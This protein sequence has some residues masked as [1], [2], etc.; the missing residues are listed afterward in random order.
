M[1]TDSKTVVAVATLP[2]DAGHGYL[3]PE[4][5][6]VWATLA[7]ALITLGLA[8]FTFR[9]YR[10]TVRI[11]RTS[12]AAGRDQADKMERSIAQAL[13]AATA[14]EDMVSAAK[15]NAVQMQG[16]LQKQMRA[17]LV[18]EVGSGIFQDEK[19]SRFGVL[20]I[21]VNSGFTP[22]HAVTYWAKAEIFPFPL[23]ENLGLAKPTA[24]PTHSMVLGPKQSFQINAFLDYPVS[25]AEVLP[26]KQGLVRRL[27]IWGEV[28]YK[29]V[30]DE[31][32]TTEFCQSVYW[33]PNGK[34]GEMIYGNYDMS[35][36][37][38]T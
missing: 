6:L 13:R 17:Y 30:F 35:R 19:Q 7:L 23:P 33:T 31:D 29:D 26:L 5:S 37:R 9:L 16:A 21:L 18:V 28:R 34:G 4:W 15:A 25:D 14:I 10:I 2:V 27:Y 1:T 38:A 20:P 32:H 8:V 22:A 11:N 36:N 3:G 24:P 12:E